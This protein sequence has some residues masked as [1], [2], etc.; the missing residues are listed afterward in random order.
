MQA[1]C[2]LKN[3]LPGRAVILASTFGKVFHD[4]GHRFAECLITVTLFVPVV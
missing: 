4:T 3:S 2:R 1:F